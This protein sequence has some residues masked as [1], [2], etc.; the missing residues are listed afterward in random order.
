M[1]LLKIILTDLRRS[2]VFRKTIL[3]TYSYELNNEY[4]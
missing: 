1:G 3:L 4:I 2:L